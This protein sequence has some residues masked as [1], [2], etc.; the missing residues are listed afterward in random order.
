MTSFP[1]CKSP[2][3][4]HG[5]SKIGAEMILRVDSNYV[6]ILGGG[7]KYVLFSPLLGEMI[8]FD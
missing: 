7:F 6:G 5:A 4:P 2:R 8:H 3:W 1:S